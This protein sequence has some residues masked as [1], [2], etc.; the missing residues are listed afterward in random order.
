MFKLYVGKADLNVDLK[1]CVVGSAMLQNKLWKELP[2]A[3][4]WLWSVSFLSI[5][6]CV[7]DTC[8]KNLVSSLHKGAYSMIILE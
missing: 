2:K 7:V 8:F 6:T 5:E 3:R 1:C 4:S